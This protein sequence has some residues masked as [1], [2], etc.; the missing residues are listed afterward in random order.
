MQTVVDKVCQ[1]VKDRKIR[2]PAFEDLH[3]PI[4]STLDGDYL[5][6]DGEDSSLVRTAV[7]LMLV[8]CVEWVRTSD[9]IAKSITDSLERDP[10]SPIQILSLGPGF[11]SILKEPGRRLKNHPVETIDL[12]GCPKPADN[13]PTTALNDIAIVGMSVVYPNGND[14]SD[15]WESLA[16]GLNSVEEASLCK[17]LYSEKS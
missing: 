12:S 15:L 16:K 17:T 4:R 11:E 3:K 2:F 13:P 7:H 1:D 8:D 10:A 6:A 9:C 14:A 5:T